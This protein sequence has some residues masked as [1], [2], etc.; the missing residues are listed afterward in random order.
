[1]TLYKGYS[2]TE[3]HSG[4]TDVTVTPYKVYSATKKATVVLYRGYSARE[5]H[6]AAVHRFQRDVRA[7]RCHSNGAVRGVAAGARSSGAGLG[8]PLA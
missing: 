3:N 1:M 2:A 7:P 6:S 4:T 8:A 5:S